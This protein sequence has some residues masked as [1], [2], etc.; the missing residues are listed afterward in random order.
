MILVQPVPIDY[1]NRVWFDVEVFLLAA[2]RHQDEYT[3]MQ[4][5]LMVTS[6]QW[7]LIV[8]TKDSD[9]IGCVTVNYYNRPDGRVAHITYAGGKLMSTKESLEGFK[10]IV[11]AAGATIIEGAGRPSVSRLMRKHFG[12]HEKHTVFQLK[13]EE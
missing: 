11:A 5:K 2:L 10:Y 7:Q 8:V 13:L 12:F 9:I 6:G 1:V 4:L 3:L